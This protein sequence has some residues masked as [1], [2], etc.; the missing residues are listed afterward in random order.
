MSDFK[1]APAPW[2]PYKDTQLL[3]ELRA[4]T[5]EQLVRHS[6]PDFR[7]E[8]DINPGA[9]GM[10]DMYQRIV[11]SDLN[12]R[13]VVMVC[14]NPNP[15]DYMPVARLINLR[16]INCRNVFCFTMDEWADDQGNI[17]PTDYKSGFTYSFMKYFY[18]MIDPELRMPESNIFYPTNENIDDYSK[19]L[20][21]CGEGGADV[22]YSGPGWAAHVAFI[23]PCPEFMPENISIEDYCKQPAK[24][25]TLHPLTIM[26]NS[27]HGVFGCS[28]DIANVPPKAATI[29]PLDVMNAKDIIE[30][31]SLVTMGTFSSWQRMTSRLICHGPVTP[32]VPG[33]IL[34]LRKT[35][36]Y[37]S[38]D[39]A[40]P[41]EVMEKVGY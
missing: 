18:G 17:A 21:E 31:H 26:Q 41:I 11:D 24:V 36:V 25:V 14:G 6:N 29:G 32:L 10:M 38:E 15:G 30:V 16:R 7:I 28:G 5:P 4:M 34:Q 9:I 2:V 22:V 13:K 37:L 39:I 35:A 8:I 40:A 27:L 33:S 23:D 19:L 20:T 12:N 3:D 1:F